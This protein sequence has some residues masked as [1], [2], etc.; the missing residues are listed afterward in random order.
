VIKE[1]VTPADIIAYLNTL[2]ETDHGAML[3]IINHRVSCNQ[4]LAK[5]PTVQV[6]SDDNQTTEDNQATVSIVGI[7]NGLFGV[8]DD[9]PK[10]N[11]GTIAIAGVLDDKKQRFRSLTEFSLVKNE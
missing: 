9:G 3:E 4:E 8:F 7:L 10:K 1:S 6:W 2:I 11:W 5:H